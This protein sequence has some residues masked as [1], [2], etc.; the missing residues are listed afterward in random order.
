[1]MSNLACNNRDKGVICETNN[2]YYFINIANSSI[3]VKNLPIDILRSFVT[4]AELGGFTYAGELLGRSQP[5]I[6]LQI[7]RLEELVGSP[8]FIRNGHQLLLSN[9][10]KVLFGYAQQILR[11]NDDAV[12]Q[13]RQSDVSGKV[14]LGIPSE[15]ATALLPKIVGRF[16]KTY[17]GVGLE[18][19]CD[20]SRNLLA[21]NKK[22]EF[23]LI[24]ALHD[25]PSTKRGSQIKA[26]DL[27]WVSSADHDAHAQTVVPLIVAPD[28]CIYRNRGIAQLNKIKQAWK[29]VYTNQD[30]SGIQAAIEEGLGVTVLAKSTVPATLKILKPSEKFPELGKIGISLLYKKSTANEAT[31]RLTD[32]LKASLV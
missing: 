2:F 11:L 24:L 12:S 10:G 9:S 28:P 4:I 7:K 16:S 5:A 32:Y 20:L 14:R 3:S 26:D 25:N 30:L 27:V 29:I 21:D 17:P 31:A 13:L 6:S 23:D 1:M 18:V 8:V 15:F 22:D 19:K